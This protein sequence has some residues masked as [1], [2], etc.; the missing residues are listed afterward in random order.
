MADRWKE[1]V[2]MMSQWRQT[3]IGDTQEHINGDHNTPDNTSSADGFL[4]MPSFGRSV[5]VRPDGQPVL[6]PIEEEE[7]TSMLLDHHSRLISNQ[8]VLSI[9]PDEEGEEQT[10]ILDESL[11]EPDEVDT[12][13]QQPFR[14][15][16]DHDIEDGES[17]LDLED[18][19]QTAPQ[20]IAS[21]ARR[22][23]KIRKSLSPS[24]ARQPLTTSNTN[25]R[26][27]KNNSTSYSPRK[28]RSISS[29]INTL[30]TSNTPDLT[31][32]TTDS[33]NTTDTLH[34]DNPSDTEDDDGEDPFLAE[35]LKS[36]STTI[37]RMTV[38]QKLA[39]IE[40]E[41]SEATEVIRRRQATTY[42]ASTDRRARGRAEKSTK[43]AAMKRE[44]K[45]NTPQARSQEIESD[46][47]K[48]RDREQAK[49]ARDRRRSTLTP[50]E[51]GVL[52][53]R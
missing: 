8:S 19:P 20:F 39:A 17:H 34:L 42:N 36:E 51:L 25:S 33:N 38:A 6:D 7:L 48:T 45:R 41:A 52:M 47:V 13:T 23:I 50:G 28:R 3:T 31:T 22:G 46:S 49:K 35:E 43:A 24:P 26:K 30:S 29:P 15:Q 21:P 4:E 14:I 12:P 32:S 10:S 11:A 40:A 27:R 9:E 16:P 1:A 18:K 5:A 44:H 53:G 37:P 2:S